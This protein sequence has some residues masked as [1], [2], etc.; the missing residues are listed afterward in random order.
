MDLPHD[1]LYF[2]SNLPSS[3]SRHRADALRRLGSQ[4]TVVDMEALLGATHRWLKFLD[5]RM[6]Y[7]WL[8]RGLL[9][10][11]KVATVDAGLRPNLIW[12]DS[13]ELF[14]TLVLRW[15]AV[16]FPCPIVL[17]S[18]DDPT[19]SRDR[20]RFQ[21]LRTALPHYSLC[22]FVRQETSLEA[23]ALGAP[24]VLTV[25]RSYDEIHHCLPHSA[26]A[27]VVK[28]IVSFIGTMI[29]GEARDC[30]LLAL[31]KVGLPL[32][33]FGNR[34]QRSR[35]WPLLRSIYQGPGLCGYAYSKAL[36]SAAVVLGL[37][38]H[39]NRDLITQRSLEAPACGG[40]LC[41]ELTSEHQLL[42]EQDHAAV[43]W[44]S[45]DECIEQCQRLLAEP[46]RSASI[47]AAGQHQVRRLGVGNEDVCRQILAAL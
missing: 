9:R 41:A 30:F 34:W 43:F 25:H 27:P 2:G 39:Q 36:G 6:G 14:G 5:Y 40:L 21:N 46:Q 17:Y 19:G 37:L 35:Y 29:P 31:L 4:V 3:T 45:I 18:L 8:Q 42:Y 33:L 11:V 22:V 16:L 23:L 15:L 26:S 44:S 38:S 13:G 12:I 24:R 32:R 28:Q 7:R 20:L 10:A 1:I 47:R